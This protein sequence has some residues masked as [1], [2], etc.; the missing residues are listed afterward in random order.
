MKDRISK[1]GNRRP[2]EEPAS[3]AGARCTLLQRKCACGAPAGVTGTCEACRERQASLQDFAV[4][5]GEHSQRRSTQTS[6]TDS[7]GLPLETGARAAMESRFSHDFSKV[8]VHVD[9]PAAESARAMNASAYTVGH[10]V[11]FSPGK[12]DPDSA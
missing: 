2:R 12:F 1:A 7:P 11:V 9:G 6:A 5:R 8:R 4:P 3:S 10:D